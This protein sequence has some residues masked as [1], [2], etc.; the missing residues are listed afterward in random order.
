MRSFGVGGLYITPAS[1]IIPVQFAL[2]QDVTFD[3]SF[4]EKLL[5]GQ[6]Q[7]PVEVARAKGKIS[8]KAAFAEIRAE[9]FN[10]II[11]G[12]VTT[13]MKMISQN[14]AATIPAVSGPYT[15]TP[16]VPASG[17]FVTNLVV[18][19]VNDT[20]NPPVPMTP[21]VS[22]P[23]TGQ[24]TISASGVY[25]FASADAGQNVQITY[26]YSITGGKTLTVTNQLMGAAPKFELRAFNTYGDKQVGVRLPRA[27]SNKLGLAMKLEDFTIPDFEMAAFADG[28]G[29]VIY[30]YT[31]E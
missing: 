23:T 28:A 17:T 15:V 14:Q 1:S 24:Y 22:G 2:L 30:K 20:T 6:Y 26:E 29:N 16:T 11:G 13:G 19:N 4:D 5:H 27:T 10:Q 9:A 7:F 21:V 3:I 25:T 31:K 18:E 8:I 12:T